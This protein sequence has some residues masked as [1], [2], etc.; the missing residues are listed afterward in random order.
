MTTRQMDVSL[1]ISVVMAA[2]FFEGSL[3]I[4]YGARTWFDITQQVIITQRRTP[5][6]WLLYGYPAADQASH[7]LSTIPQHPRAFRGGRLN[8]DCPTHTKMSWRCMHTKASLGSGSPD[9]LM[10]K[11]FSLPG[12]P[13][14]C[15]IPEP[16]QLMPP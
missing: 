6:P 2:V 16:P 9:G 10:S 13:A 7:F 11:P 1:T 3:R 15:E 5:N 12:L 4:S 14:K 8:N